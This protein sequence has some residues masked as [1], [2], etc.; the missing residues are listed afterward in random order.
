MASELGRSSQV[1]PAPGHASAPSEVHFPF[2]RLMGWHEGLPYLTTNGMVDRATGIPQVPVYY[3]IPA[4]LN[5]VGWCK[6]P[7]GDQPSIDGRCPCKPGG[8]L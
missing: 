5:A 2:P 4:V 7:M 3:G 8:P 6:S 1:P